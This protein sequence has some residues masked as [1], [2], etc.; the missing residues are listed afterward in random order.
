MLV[1]FSKPK[2]RFGRINRRSN[3][4]VP[5]FSRVEKCFWSDRLVL[6]DMNKPRSCLSYIDQTRP[7][8]SVRS[9]E[10]LLTSTAPKGRRP[11]AL[12]DRAEAHTALSPANPG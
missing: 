1:V 2:N 10:Y 11:R 4:S 6:R 5:E 12:D 3:D 9:S 8:Q 7:R